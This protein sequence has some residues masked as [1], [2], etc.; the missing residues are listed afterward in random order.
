[1][2]RS[3]WSR[4]RAADRPPSKSKAA[5]YNRDNATAAAVILSAPQRHSRFQVN[6]A[7]AFTQRRAEESREKIG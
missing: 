7:K 1:M 2:N 5:Q 3:H 6:W 4:R